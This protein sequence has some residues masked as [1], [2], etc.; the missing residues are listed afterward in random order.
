MEIKKYGMGLFEEVNT[1]M[2]KISTSLQNLKESEFIEDW[3]FC[4]TTPKKD[5]SLF[6]NVIKEQNKQITILNQRMIQLR[7]KLIKL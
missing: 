6:M 5:I 4:K 3:K 2:L 7:E 1:E